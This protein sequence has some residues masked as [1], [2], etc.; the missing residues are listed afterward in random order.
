MAWYDSLTFQGSPLVRIFGSMGIL[1]LESGSW[2]SC[3][4]PPSRIDTHGDD[5][6]PIALLP[7]KERSST[8]AS[9]V[10]C[11]MSPNRPG[12]DGR[13]SLSTGEG[14]LWQSESSIC[15]E[16]DTEDVPLFGGRGLRE[17][18]DWAFAFE[19]TQTSAGGRAGRGWC[20]KLELCTGGKHGVEGLLCW[21]GEGLKEAET[22]S[23]YR[24]GFG[25]LWI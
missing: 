4:K 1:L 5:R 12:L 15:D 3:S 17:I 10:G 25:V 24:R 6:L 9:V 19:V 14:V 7:S 20:L 11:S 22:G 21:E 2:T 13:V 16:L 23:G 18:C 8:G